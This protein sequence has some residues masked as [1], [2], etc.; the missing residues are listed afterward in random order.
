MAAIERSDALLVLGSSLKVYSGY[1]F[2][3]QAAALGKPI[4]IINRGVTRGDDLANLKLNADCGSVL[5]YTVQ[6]I[7]A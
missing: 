5:A 3:K 2:C 4:A 7:S 6:A 1:R